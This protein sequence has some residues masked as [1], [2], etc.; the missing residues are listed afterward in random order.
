MSQRSAVGHGEENNSIAIE[1]D[2]AMV[3][4]L[5]RW[6]DVYKKAVIPK[7]VRDG[8]VLS[9]WMSSMRR[10]RKSLTEEQVKELDDAGMVWKMN[11]IESKWFANFHILREFKE[12]HEIT[13][14]DAYFGHDDPKDDA[15]DTLLGTGEMKEDCDPRNAEARL[16]TSELIE[17]SR[18]LHRQHSL[19][20]KQKLNAMQ[21]HLL[22]R[23]L[24][25]ALYR[26][27]GPKRRNIHQKILQANDTFLSQ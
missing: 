20:R 11:T 26:Q 10:L 24:G 15:W 13:Q 2:P 12:E 19:Y 18:W 3:D 5:R 25:A 7:S 17:A 4:A 21:V 8:Q 9:Q 27:H 6:R 14:I 1:V 16:R 22:K 23:V